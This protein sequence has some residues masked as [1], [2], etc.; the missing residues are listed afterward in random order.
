MGNKLEAQKKVHYITI[1]KQFSSK[2][3]FFS[4]CL[5]NWLLFSPLFYGLFSSFQRK[6]KVKI[7]LDST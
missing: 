7:K 1:P 5:L 4:L 3:F 2:I 6:Q